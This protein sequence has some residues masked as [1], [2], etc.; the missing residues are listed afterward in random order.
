M[1]MY[2]W[3]QFGND[4]RNGDYAVFWDS[5]RPRDENGTKIRPWLQG[6]KW[7]FR[8][9]NKKT[10]FSQFALTWI[11]VVEYTPANTPLKMYPIN[12]NQTRDSFNNPTFVKVNTKEITYSNDSWTNKD[13]IDTFEILEEWLYYIRVSWQFLFGM[14]WSSYDSNN[15]YKYAWYIH[16]WQENEKG[17]RVLRQAKAVRLCWDGATYDLSFIQMLPQW[18]FSFPTFSTTYPANCYCYGMYQIVKLW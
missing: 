7:S 1:I 10:D 17:E 13:T 2:A 12:N 3:K 14:Y 4:F 8:E 16:L 6:D 15:S 18:H 9:V 11:A 5:N